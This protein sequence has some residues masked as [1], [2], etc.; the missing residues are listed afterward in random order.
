MK[1]LISDVISP[2]SFIIESYLLGWEMIYEVERNG[3]QSPNFK[4]LIEQSKTLK[5]SY[6]ARNLYWSKNL[7]IKELRD[8]MIKDSFIPARK[9]YSVF[10]NKLVVELKKG[11]VDLAK[12]TMNVVLTSLFQKHRRTIDKVV[13][14]ADSKTIEIE[15]EMALQLVKSH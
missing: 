1:D 10:D 12:K 13:L 9:F 15:S 14:K 2:D 3:K 8:A 4:T 6:M 11:N 5:A 7:K